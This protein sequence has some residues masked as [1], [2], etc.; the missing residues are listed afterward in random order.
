MTDEREGTLQRD[1]V[2]DMT[3]A[4]CRVRFTYSRTSDGRWIVNGSMQCGIEDRQGERSIVTE[5]FHNREEAERNA[6]EQVATSL[7]QHTDRSHSRV[8]NWS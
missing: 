5:A 7:G 6:I 1:D 2:K 8:R 4:G 3:I